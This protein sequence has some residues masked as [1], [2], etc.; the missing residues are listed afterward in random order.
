M[1]NYSLILAGGNGTRFWPLSRQI[2]PKQVLNLSGNDAM[3]NETIKRINGLVDYEDTYVITNESQRSAIENILYSSVSRANILTE[4][5]GRNTA[6]CILYSAMHIYKE[7]GDAVLIVLPSDAFIKNEAVFEEVLKIAVKAAEE[8]SDILTVGI[9]P[10]FPATGYGYIKRGSD[11][12]DHEASKVLE[13]VE[14]PDVEHARQYLLSGQYL[15]NG[16]IFIF[17]L[18]VI[19]ENFKRFLPRMYDLFEEAMP[20]FCTEREFEAL[21]SV[22]DKI[23]PISIDYGLLERS[24]DVSVVSGDFGWSDV[25]SWDMLGNVFNP[26]EQ[27]NIVK[28]NHVG[29][30]D[31]DC[32]IYSD[33]DKMIA[34]VGLNEMIIVDT[35]DALLVCPKNHAQDVRKIVD[36]LKAD[37]RNEL[38]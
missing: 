19:I 30:D 20:D 38:I 3:I 31:N 6:P 12:A 21:K 25:G 2:S 29:I 32:I 9:N 24:N 14:K 33:G 18:S 15:W 4:P 13:F 35:S 23:K 27:G 11:C 26:D 37:G 22:Y 5:F 1:K 16:G 34:T 17:K 8:S 10:T 28:A 36:K 7:H